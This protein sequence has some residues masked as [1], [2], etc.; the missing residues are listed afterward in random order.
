MRKTDQRMT[1]FYDSLTDLLIEGMEN[2]DS[3][4]KPWQAVIGAMYPANAET[5]RQYTGINVW[6]LM[7]EQTVADYPTAIWATYRQWKRI[8][9]TIKQEVWDAEAWTWG[10]RW[11]HYTGKCFDCKDGN[12]DCQDDSHTMQSLMSPRYFKLY[13][14]EQVDGVTAED[15]QGALPNGAERIAEAEALARAT[16]IRIEHKPSDRAFYMPGTDTITMP[17]PEQFKT[18]E[19]YYSTLFHEIG[20]ATGHKDRLERTQGKWFGSEQYAFEELVA[21][22]SQVYIMARL[23]LAPEPHMNS[24]SYVASWLRAVKDNSEAVGKAARLAAKAADWVFKQAEETE[25]KEAA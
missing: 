3:W 9:G 25:V 13:N 17:D 8:G 2:A 23:G 20:H 11:Q 16:G 6:V 24:A 21:E 10:E 4:E 7:A 1:D 14:L 12:R 15:V 18:T 22:L 5:K 19:G